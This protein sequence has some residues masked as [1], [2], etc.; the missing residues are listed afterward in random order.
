[1]KL[2]IIVCTFNRSYAIAQCLNSIAESLSAAAPI[3]A[4]IVVVD[5]ASTDNTSAVVKEWAEKCV[6]PVQLLYEPKKGLSAARNCGLRSAH[7]ELLAFTDDDCRLSKEY[8]RD[9]LRHDAADTGPVFRGG[10]VEL[11][12][13]TDLPV[14]IKTD[15]DVI[16]MSL[17]MNSARHNDAG[18]IIGCN[19]A[20]R[21]TLANTIGFFDENLGAGTSIP[22]A[23]DTDYLYRGY[24][25]GA[26]LEYVPDTIIY[27][28]H[29]R[30][31]VT[32]INKLL[33]N[34]M[35]GLGA[36]YIKY[37]FRHINFCRPFYWD[38][39]NAVKE[40]ATGTIRCRPEFGLSYKIK[41][42]YCML[43]AFKYCFVVTKSLCHN[44]KPHEQ[45]HH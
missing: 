27:H 10:R 13:P 20:L 42:Y 39:K 16:R 23:E 31:T 22:A 9:L 19:M 29:G 11:G 34:Y 30:K 8:V 4:E 12:D 35:L 7:G 17:K 5:N 14:T 18:I 44:G 2:S 32:E 43:G 36:L 37:F 6:F 24:L 1:M 33:C 21:R 38:L 40:I 26:V 45:A 41:I 25:S 3:E 28:F 15:P